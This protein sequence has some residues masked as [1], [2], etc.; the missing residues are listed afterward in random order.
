MD[1]VSTVARYEALL[2]V[3]EA[4]R[5][6][7]DR[8][9]LFRSLARELRA[10][11]RF[12]FL[13][14]ALLDE[15]TQVVEPYVLEATGEP[16][17]P[18]QLTS[19]EQLTYWVVQHQKPL[20]IP[21]VERETRFA[22]EMEYLRTQGTHSIC[23]LPLTTPR[24]RVGMLIAGSRE[25]HVYDAEDVSFLSL[26]A[27]QIALAIDDTLNYEALQSALVLERERFRNLDASDEML[28][29]LSPVLD[30]RQVFPR[31]SH[32]AATVLSHDRLTLAF[33]DRYGE[34]AL[35]SDESG[36]LP[37]RLNPG[38]A[39]TEGDAFVII[40]SLENE[41]C[42]VVEPAG[43]WN[44]VRSAGY[45]S[46]IAVRLTAGGQT[47]DLQFWSKRPA[48]FEPGQVPIARR[49][50]DH[51]MMALSHQRLAEEAQRSAEARERTAVLERRV[52]ALTAEVD[53]LAGQRLVVG[54]SHA[55]RHVLKQAT[56]VAATDT[57]V[58]LLGESGT[59]KEVVARFIHRASARNTGPFVAI[60]C[61]A[62]PEP[63]LESELFGFERGAF[64]GAQQAKP[65]QIEQAAGGV[66][67]LDEVAE[68]SP[69]AQAKFLRV[70]QEREFQR[71]GS[72]RT[73]KANIRVVAATNRNLRAAMETGA[74]REDLYYRLHVFE[75]HL[76]PLRDRRDDILPLSEAFLQELAKSFGR[77][78]A[79]MSREARDGLR[80]YS[81]PGNVRELRNMLERAA[82]LCEGGLITGEHLSFSSAATM[83]R[84]LMRTVE[85][86]TREP[87][88]RSADTSDLRVLERATI[89]RALLDARYNKS[90]AAKQLGLS[91]KQLYVRL[92][93]HGLE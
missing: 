13:G 6:H 46:L 5:A 37:A 61:A 85:P 32:I 19:E 33:H 24:R 72:T 66:L 56:Q 47:L 12:S 64:T 54:E 14:L 59:G 62:L 29:T 57:T 79:G 45:R 80:G 63:L 35:A 71:L 53:A 31:I 42:P 60:N 15:L 77:P 20:V 91:R 67:F 17:P 43:F 73:L 49:I 70:L 82:I 93:Q 92:R 55:W 16:A 39:A 78:P 28:R 51:V 4:L 26:V 38:G 9:T 74:F 89:E 83:E 1:E 76:P 22:Q 8:E 7:H 18:P 84:Q 40:G 41:T 86:A 68:M 87:E 52:T 58:L 11:V 25:P 36:P 75:I 2:R 3:S 48:A 90:V 10:V 27:N 65:G 81:W 34:I 30:I 23:C 88:V 21:V 69:S 44:R 50:G